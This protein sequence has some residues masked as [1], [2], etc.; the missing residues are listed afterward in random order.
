MNLIQRIFIGIVF[1]CSSSYGADDGVHLFMLSGQS[2]MARMEPNKVFTP[3]VEKHF[4]KE[5]VVVVKVAKGGQPIRRWDKKWSVTGD[6]D[7]KQ[8]GD[9]YE[10]LIK[11]TKEALA[12]RK[13]KTATFIWMQGERDA[14][15][16]LSDLYEQS[17]L[18][19][20]DQIR[21]DLSFDELHYVIG[22]LSDNGIGKAQW[23]RMREIQVKL[24]DASP[25]GEWVNTDDL[26]DGVHSKTG[27][28]LKNDLH[29]TVEGYD[30]LARRYV[31]KAIK[32]I[33]K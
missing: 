7:P 17:F 27:K 13:I 33:E 32:L 24:A 19:I 14:K 23:D 1:C 11:A 26:N 6:Q 15:D 31:E 4:G 20:L 2:N 3:S 22:R 30:I 5:N 29:Y 16:S 10:N 28:T 12:G 8:I 25:L 18:G 9:L 21:T